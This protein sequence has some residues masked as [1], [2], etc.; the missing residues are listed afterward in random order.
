[1]SPGPRPLALLATAALGLIVTVGIGLWLRLGLAGVAPLVGEFAFVRHAHTHAG[2]YL[3][4]FPL[5][6]LAWRRL[7]TNAPGPRLSALYGVAA[8]A[9]ILAFA[10]QGYA[11]ASIAASTIV[12]VGWLVSAVRA[13][14]AAPGW[15]GVAPAGIVLATCFVPPIGLSASRDP[16]LTQA[17]V[18]SF[19]S[20]LLLLVLIPTALAT[21]R[22]PAPPP[23]LWGGLSALSC[24]FFGALPRGPL[25][26]AL[27]VQGLLLARAL[28]RAP[29]E[30]PL[31]LAWGGVAVGLMAAGLQGGPPS[32]PRAIAAVHALVLGPLFV[33]LAPPGRAL[34]WVALLAAAGM[35]AALVGVEAGLDGRTSNLLAALAGAL[36]LPA[37]LAGVR[38]LVVPPGLPP[39]R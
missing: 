9:A 8:F 29:A 16:A 30:L 13:F 39:P 10:L 1:M 27:S 22:L 24:A 7:G 20:V 5:A 15:L 35:G 17:L 23:L 21:L 31:R 26:V 36:W 12:G 4:L 34:T 32:G 38:A 3:V 19:L 25:G 28:W 18:Q 33:T 14:R 2:Y 11:L 6:W 37:G